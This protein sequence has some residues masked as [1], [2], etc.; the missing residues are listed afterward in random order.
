[1]VSLMKNYHLFGCNYMPDF[2]KLNFDPAYIAKIFMKMV[3][4]INYWISIG[5]LIS[6]PV[7]VYSM[8]PH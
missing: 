8:T 2:I 3:T 5:H 6:E 7:E 4:T 1:M